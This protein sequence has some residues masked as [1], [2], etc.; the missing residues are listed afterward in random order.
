MGT[1]IW[2]F[3]NLT[4][5]LGGL[6][7]YLRKPLQEFVQTR[8]QMIRDRLQTVQKEMQQARARYQEVSQKL[9][10]IDPEIRKLK[11]QYEQE[12]QQ[13]R[14]QLLDRTRKICQMTLKDAQAQSRSMLENLKTETR[15]EI[16][17]QVIQRTVELL[18]EKLTG[19]DRERFRKEFSREMEKAT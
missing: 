19:A 16:S 7:Y 9:E 1:L 11:N 5:L 12:A 15:N 10:Q 6:V 8:H 2:P 13:N 18:K 4:V 17:S 14:D 3:I